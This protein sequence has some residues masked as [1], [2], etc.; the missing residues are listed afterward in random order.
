MKI[1]KNPPPEVSRCDR[2]GLKNHASVSVT[3]AVSVSSVCASGS[4]GK[5]PSSSSSTRGGNF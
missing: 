1:A 5:G 4:G 3:S 2:V